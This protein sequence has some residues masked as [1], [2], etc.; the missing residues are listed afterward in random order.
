MIRAIG[1]LFASGSR[2]PATRLSEAEARAIARAAVPDGF[3]KDRMTITKV[4]SR[5]GRLLW[6][7]ES[8]TR[9]SGL[10]VTIED[11]TGQVIEQKKWGVR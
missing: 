1:R 6:H 3:F 2:P 5:D 11:A 10:R 7:I 4:E 9:G 8:A